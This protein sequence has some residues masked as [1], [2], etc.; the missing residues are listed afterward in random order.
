MKLLQRYDV[1]KAWVEWYFKTLDGSQKQQVLKILHEGDANQK[2][3]DMK[4]TRND[5]TLLFGLQLCVLI[6]V[7]V[8]YCFNLEHPEGD[9]SC[10]WVYYSAIVMYKPYTVPMWVCL[11]Y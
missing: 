7:L 4:E 6:G 2:D 10:Q 1:S 3:L 11:T 9:F 8:D 5:T